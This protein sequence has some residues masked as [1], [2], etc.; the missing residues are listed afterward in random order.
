MKTTRVLWCALAILIT[1]FSRGAKVL[2]T[3]RCR[4]LIGLWM[5]DWLRIPDSVLGSRF[6]RWRIGRVASNQA[7]RISRRFLVFAGQEC[8]DQ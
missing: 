4:D 2:K 1:Q 7:G 3:L 5:L 8:Y 6:G